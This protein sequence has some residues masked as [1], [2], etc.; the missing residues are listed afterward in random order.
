MSNEFYFTNFRQCNKF[1]INATSLHSRVGKRPISRTL[2]KSWSSRT[3]PLAISFEKSVKC[4]LD[5]PNAILQDIR[6]DIA[7]FWKLTLCLYQTS[8]LPIVFG[9]VTRLNN[10][11]GEGTMLNRTTIKVP[12]VETFAQPIVVLH[13]QQ[14]QPVLHLGR[15]AFG[16]SKAILVG[17]SH[18]SILTQSLD[19]YVSETL[20]A[21]SLNAALSGRRE[22]P[23][24]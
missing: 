20:S 8:L 24:G 4:F 1:F 3:L 19:S 10:A 5:S 16:W 11:T 13:P 6:I 2:L 21:R 7:I 23:C 15:L 22:A 14:I 9:L 12:P 17:S 18:V